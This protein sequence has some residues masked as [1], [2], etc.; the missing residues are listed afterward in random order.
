METT[1]IA[2]NELIQGFLNGLGL[3]LFKSQLEVMVTLSGGALKAAVSLAAGCV[4]ITKFLPYYTEAVPSSLVAIVAATVATKVRWLE[5]E[6][7][8]PLHG[9]A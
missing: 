9:L 7:E 6:S 5:V 8:M 2:C 4:A 1:I 3:L